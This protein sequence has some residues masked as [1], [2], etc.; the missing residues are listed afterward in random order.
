MN[1]VIIR[2]I[3]TANNVE[4]DLDL[5][6]FNDFPLAINKGIVNLDNLKERTGTFTKMFKVPNSKNNTNKMFKVP[7]SKN[8]TNLLSN[9]DNINSRK[10]FRDCLNKKP[11]I[12]L[13]NNNPVEHGFVQVVKAFN[14]VEGGYFELVFYGNNID[15]VKDASELKLNTIIWTNN[16]ITYNQGN[17]DAI[18]NLT[19]SFTDIAFPY[20]SR[21]GNAITDA[22]SV[23]DFLPCIY[24]RNLITKS[25]NSLGYKVESSL[26]T[27]IRHI[28]C[29]LSLNISQ[30]KS[31]VE[32]S[33][34]RA[35]M[36][37]PTVV[38]VDPDTTKRIIF[39]DDSTFP[40]EDESGYYNS[41]TGIYT[42]PTTGTYSITVLVNSFN[43][44][45]D[46][47][48]ELRV[49][50][51]GDS[52]T[53]IGSGNV[54]DTQYLEATGNITKNFNV[55]LNAGDELSIY[56]NPDEF[57]SNLISFGSGTYFK[58]Q[59][60]SEV[61]EGS[62]FSVNSLIPDSVKFLDILND[63]TRMFNVYYWTD[64]KTKT[65]YFE[66]RDNFFKSKTTAIDWSDKLDTSKGYN[67][68]YVSSYK[69][70]INFG[71]KNDTNDKYLEEW[72]NLN[73]RTYGKYT[74]ELPSRFSKGNTNINLDFFSATY[75]HK[76]KEVSDDV[77]FTTL[78]IWN[79]YKTEPDT[80][81]DKN[82]KYKPRIFFHKNGRQESS[83]GY[84]RSIKINNGLSTSVRTV[85]AYGIFETYYNI[86]TPHLHWSLNFADG[87]K[88]DGVTTEIGLFNRFYSKM[89]KNI[90]EG[91][92]IIAYFDLNSTDIQNLDFRELI[93]LDGDSN[94]KGYYLIEKV[95]D[96]NPLSSELT[97]VSLF[98]FE[99]L[100]SV[101]IDGSQTGTNDSDTDDGLTPPTLQPIYVENGALLIEVYIENPITGLI[102][103][104]YK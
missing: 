48:G 38:N 15:W 82:N 55:V 36:T 69:R 99:D 52:T 19:G 83:N 24:I 7:N 90:E 75:A 37:T 95:I 45:A 71:Y 100:G 104:V 17:I 65:V 58:T 56:I 86:E 76:A 1:Q 93:Y 66:P 61:E 77:G 62:T 91:G 39:N 23:T 78:K 34:A 70:N 103:P 29:D 89:F 92:R 60:T 43:T 54:L 9:V 18:N 40:N 74:H 57:S 102:E 20:I 44:G 68:D 12:I 8:N 27:D 21:G 31:N 49:V 81:E 26:L 22:T 96:Y 94:V 4:G 5:T 30:S 25:F 53:S 42:V 87:L 72:N 85:M 41:S 80:P 28:V 16:T 63:I 14:D 84:E 33:K 67:V 35:S 73:K 46:A 97:K 51:N 32:A 2:I 47:V 13:I 10:D 6:N 59:L 64:V 3:D 88:P 11:C 79:E 98:K 50:K 101:S